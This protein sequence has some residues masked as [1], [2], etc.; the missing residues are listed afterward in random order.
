[1]SQIRKPTLSVDFDG[2]IHQYT[3]PWTNAETIS[4]GPVPGALRW[5][6]KATEWFEVAIYSSR[7]KNPIARGAMCGWMQ[8]HSAEEFGADH[9]MADISVSTENYPILFAHEKPAAFLTI[10]DRAICFEGD[11]SELEPADL[12]LFK[13]WNKRP[14]PPQGSP[15]PERE[16]LEYA[17][18]N[19]VNA[20]ICIMQEGGKTLPM[21]TEGLEQIRVL[22]AALTRRAVEKSEQ[23][24]A[25]IEALRKW[26]SFQSVENTSTLYNA[27]FALFDAKFDPREYDD[28]E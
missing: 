4:D 28:V 8:R 5:L 6:W 25:A 27:A 21:A 2:V 9:P 3:S 26:F 16:A 13:P 11:W 7:S 20:F 14:T 12:L 22:R 1:M 17:L 10:D 18:A 15:S 23:E 19:I 24:K